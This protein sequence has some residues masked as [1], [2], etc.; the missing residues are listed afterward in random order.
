MLLLSGFVAAL[1]SEAEGWEVLLLSGFVARSVWPASL[2]AASKKVSFA[3]PCANNNCGV[4]KSEPKT[5]EVIVRQAM[6]IRLENFSVRI[7]FIRKKVIEFR[8][9]CLQDWLH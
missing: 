4:A 7:I 8:F 9:K 5:I 1:L 3:S 2:T 6:D